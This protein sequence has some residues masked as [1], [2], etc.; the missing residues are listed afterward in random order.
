MNSSNHHLVFFYFFVALIC[1]V[2]KN[3]RKNDVVD[4]KKY[5]YLYIK[6]D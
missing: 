5:I 3:I 2:M 6:W 1:Y 4:N